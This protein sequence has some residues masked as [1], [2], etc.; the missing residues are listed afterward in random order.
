MK[1]STQLALPNPHRFD[2]YGHFKVENTSFL[3]LFPRG[4]TWQ[5]KY[6]TKYLVKTSYLVFYLKSVSA[7]IPKLWLFLLATKL[8]K[9]TCL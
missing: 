2:L 5:V 7:I 3:F 6:K 1:L 4:I 9:F 8:L